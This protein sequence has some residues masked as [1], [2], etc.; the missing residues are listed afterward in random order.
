MN[1]LKEKNNSLKKQRMKAKTV[2]IKVKILKSSTIQTE[3]AYNKN[4]LQRN[5]SLPELN[6]Q[7][8]FFC[9]N[10]NIQSTY[11][12]LQKNRKSEN[13]YNENINFKDNLFQKSAA[14]R[15]HNKLFPIVNKTI[16]KTANLQDEKTHK[17]CIEL[18]I[19][20]STTKL[21]RI[22]AC[23]YLKTR[24]PHNLILHLIKKRRVKRHKALYFEEKT[25]A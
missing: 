17:E 18:K 21:K 16:Y 13:Y 6:N 9:L 23:H 7:E 4:V 1:K 2:K 12:K 3:R 8:L 10:E 5:N 20:K 22:E 11:N 15:I 25:S 19:P 24:I 14:G